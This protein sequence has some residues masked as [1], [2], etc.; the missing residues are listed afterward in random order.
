MEISADWLTEVIEYEIVPLVEE[1]WVD[2]DK[3]R[4]QAL[5]ILRGN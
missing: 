3:K 2:D 4:N 5:S 1:Y